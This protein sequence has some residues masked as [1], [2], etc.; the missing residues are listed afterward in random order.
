MPNT[1]TELL[2]AAA[3]A[4]TARDAYALERLRQRAA[5]WLQTAEE[6]AAQIALLDAMI[7]AA[8]LLEE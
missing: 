8:Y 5:D 1:L 6:T 7:E 2:A 3:E 4:L